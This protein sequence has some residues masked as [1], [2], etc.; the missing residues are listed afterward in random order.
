MYTVLSNCTFRALDQTSRLVRRL[1][2]SVR[3]PTVVCVTTANKRL[4]HYPVHQHNH[5]AVP[6]MMPVDAFKAKLV[7]RAKTETPPIP[8]I[9]VDEIAKL[10]RNDQV[11][12]D[13]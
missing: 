7:H 13:G 8:K 1:T 12:P 3:Y 2:G 6:F 4:Q 11:V 5:A 9:H 10:R